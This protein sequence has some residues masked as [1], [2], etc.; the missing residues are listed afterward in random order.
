MPDSMVTRLITSIPKEILSREP[1]PLAPPDD[2]MYS[3][4]WLLFTKGDAPHA[5]RHHD[6]PAHDLILGGGYEIDLLPNE[7]ADQNEETPVDVSPTNP[8][9]PSSK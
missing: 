9:E 2:L 3:A 4:P 5:K 7:E 1:L 6:G 8:D